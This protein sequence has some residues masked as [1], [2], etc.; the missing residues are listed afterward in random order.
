MMYVV[1]SILASGVDIILEEDFVCFALQ[2]MEIHPLMLLIRTLSMILQTFSPTLHSPRHTRVSYVGTI[3]TMVMIVYHG[4]HL[5]MSRNRATIKT[6]YQ[7]RNQNLYEPN[8]CYNSNYSGFD[9]PSQYPIDQSPPQEMSIQDMELQKQ[10][11]LDEM[12]SISNQIQIKDYHNE[13]ID[14]HYRRE[15]EIKIDELKA[16]FNKMSI[17][18]NKLTKEKELRQREQVVNLSTPEPS[19]CFNSIYYD[20][21]DDE[22]STIPLSE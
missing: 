10:Q 6:L 13:R 16:K 4:Y 12:Q 7:P 8:L 22:E 19:R 17:E 20:D 3:L 14:I 18:I 1:N 21:N 11:Y 5:S 9:R 15:C 2:E